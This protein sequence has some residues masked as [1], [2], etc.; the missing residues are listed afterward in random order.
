MFPAVDS[1]VPSLFMDSETVMRVDDLDATIQMMLYIDHTYTKAYTR[2]PSIELRDKVGQL[3]V[4][5]LTRSETCVFVKV[6]FPKYTRR[7]L[8]RW[9]SPSL[10]TSSF[11]TLASVGPH[12]T[13]SPTPQWARTIFC[14]R[15]GQNDSLSA[16]HLRFFLSTITI[17]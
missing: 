10:Q 1:P 15:T 2:A 12:S 5:G 9:L 6:S 16:A 4:T 13:P 11:C 8:W 14:F 3:L 7:Y 17:N